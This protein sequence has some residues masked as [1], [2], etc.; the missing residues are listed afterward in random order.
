MFNSIKILKRID[1]FVGPALV[2]ILPAQLQSA[3]LKNIKQILVIRPGG[4]GD[5]LLLLPALKAISKKNDSL[6][7]DILCEPR[8]QEVFYAAPDI[9]NIFSYKSPADLFFIFKKNMIL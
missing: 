6:K 1:S 8:N 4:L 9:N 2:K 7:I 5:A 3:K